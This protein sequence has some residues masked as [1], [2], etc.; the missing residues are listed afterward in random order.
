MNPHRQH[1][2]GHSRPMHGNLRRLFMSAFRNRLTDDTEVGNGIERRMQSLILETSSSSPSTFS[3]RQTASVMS[4]F[5]LMFMIWSF[6]IV[7]TGGSRAP[8]HSGAGISCCPL[9]VGGK[10]AAGAQTHHEGWQR[11]PC[12]R[13]IVVAIPHRSFPRGGRSMRFR[14]PICLHALQC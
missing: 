8:P 6:R 1:H 3:S 14:H 5:D 2:D 7:I 4:A 9:P 12:R 11:S 10:D 13:C